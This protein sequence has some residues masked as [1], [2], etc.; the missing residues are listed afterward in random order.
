MS[1]TDQASMQAALCLIKVRWEGKK[2]D[3][4]GFIVYHSLHIIRNVSILSGMLL[5]YILWIFEN[6]GLLI[7]V[8]SEICKVPKMKFNMQR[9]YYCTKKNLKKKSL[10]PM[11]GFY[12]YPGLH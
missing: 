2:K 11:S 1:L 3:F 6:I 10:E 12:S 7:Y 5:Q 8:Y 4:Y 9:R